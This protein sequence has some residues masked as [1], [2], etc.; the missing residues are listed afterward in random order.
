ML[1][2][3]GAISAVAVVAIGLVLAPA[4][5]G[6]GLEMYTLHGPGDK[7]AKGAAGVELAGQRQ[8]AGGLEAD[9]VLTRSQVA[10]LRGLG[11]D[12][13]LTRNKKGQTAQEQARAMKVGGYNVY[14]S[15]DEPGGIRDELSKVAAKNKDLVKLEVL[16]QTNQGRDLLA[17]HA[18]P[19]ANSH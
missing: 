16:G 9:A 11:V 17:L 8:T 3:V 14:R 12:V 2:R 15:W 10:K 7:I 19:H 1:S 18:Q 13:S 4:A 5:A 6:Q